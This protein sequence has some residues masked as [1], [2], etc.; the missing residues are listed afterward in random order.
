MNFVELL[1]G[2]EPKMPGAPS[3]IKIMTPQQF[4]AKAGDMPG[5]ESEEGVAEGY[6]DDSKE[7]EENLRKFAFRFNQG[8]LAAKQLHSE[9]VACLSWTRERPAESFCLSGGKGISRST[10]D[11]V[12]A[13][14]DIDACTARSASLHDEDGKV[15]IGASSVLYCYFKAVERLSNNLTRSEFSGCEFCW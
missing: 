3:G 11:A 15:K 1:E 12:V 5:E 9:I 6:Q 4:V 13:V 14:E 8:S 2:A 7:R 10:V